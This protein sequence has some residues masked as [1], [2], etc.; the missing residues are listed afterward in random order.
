MSR[1]SRKIIRFR[2]PEQRRLRALFTDQP[3]AG[4]D[5]Q[6]VAK[7][8]GVVLGHIHQRSPDRLL[9]AIRAVFTPLLAELEAATKDRGA[10]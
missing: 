2:A 7:L 8:V 10:Q 4:A 1:P 9:N 6:H 3:S 5:L